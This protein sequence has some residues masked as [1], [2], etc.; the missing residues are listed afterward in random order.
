[1][2]TA[3]AAAKSGTKRTT[4]QRSWPSAKAAQYVFVYDDETIMEPER[5]IAQASGVEPADGDS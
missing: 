2:V 4:K 5:A 3:L 1:M